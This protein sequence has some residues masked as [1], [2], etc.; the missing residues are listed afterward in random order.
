MIKPL[1]KRHLQIWAL[2]AVLIPLGI[3]G[4][5]RAIPKQ[6]FTALLQDDATAAMPVVVSKIERKN[7]SVYLRS[8]TG[9]KNYQLQWINKTVSVLPSS[10][11]YRTNNTDKELIGRV[12]S[13]GSYFF[14]LKADTTSTYRFVLYDIIHQQTIDTINFN[15]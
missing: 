10:L 3:I 14:P 9:K 12:A 2:F 5:Y 11:I 4:G 1:R 8:D 7:Y 13:T 15:R 6:A